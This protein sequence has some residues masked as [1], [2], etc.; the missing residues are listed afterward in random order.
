M[1]WQGYGPYEARRTASQM[2]VDQCPPGAIVVWL[3]THLCCGVVH[4]YRSSGSIERGTF[5]VEWKGELHD[6]YEYQIMPLGGIEVPPPGREYT[7]YAKY[8][9]RYPQGK[10]S[11]IKRRLNATYRFTVTSDF[12]D[13][14]VR[15]K[16]KGE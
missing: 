2:K 12:V 8:S 4:E 5:T 9:V 15:L 1:G 16:M 6:I 14:L 3:E 11:F 10:I 7:L 13:D